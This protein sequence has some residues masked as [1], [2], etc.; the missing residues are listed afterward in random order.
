[1]QAI[2]YLGDRHRQ[3]MTPRFKELEQ[4][5]VSALLL[6]FLEKE[7]ERPGFT[8]V[9]RE[10][11]QQWQRDKLTLKLKIDRVD[12]LDD[13]SLALIDYKS[14]KSA[15]KPASLLD[16]RPEDMQLPLYY[17]ASTE[18]QEK[19]L[20]ALTIAHVNVERIGYSGIAAGDNFHEKLKPWNREDPNWQQLTESWQQKVELLA[21]EFIDGKV[22]V[23]P[24][25]GSKTCMYCGLESLCRIRELSDSI[26]EEDD[27]EEEQ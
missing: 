10:Q 18:Q 13:G 12:E 3:L 16:T 21:T 17:V 5:R 27:L 2:D 22:Q 11:K 1:M 9:A 7:D 26:I 24:V 6:K 25:N 20:T 8:V 19:P 14:G 4:Q 23:A 15:I